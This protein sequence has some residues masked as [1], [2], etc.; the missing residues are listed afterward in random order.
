MIRVNDELLR[1]LEF[2][3]E[4]NKWVHVKGMF[5]YTNK[6]PDDLLSLVRIMNGN[7]FKLGKEKNER[8]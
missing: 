7:A 6:I 3:L 2:R 1:Y 5:I 4:G 8:V